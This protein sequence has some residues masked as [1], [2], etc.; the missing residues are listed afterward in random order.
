V[1]YGRIIDTSTVYTIM[2]QNQQVITVARLDKSK[3]IGVYFDA[4]LDFKNHAHEKT[5]KAYDVRRN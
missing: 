3:D 4:K 1:S 5:N 2:D